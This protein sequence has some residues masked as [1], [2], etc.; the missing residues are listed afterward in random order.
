MATEA[1]LGFRAF[2]TEKITGQRTIDHLELRRQVAAGHLFD[3]EL[4]EIVF[5]KP[6]EKPIKKK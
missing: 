1:N 6:L 4:A 3:D 5:P 2:A